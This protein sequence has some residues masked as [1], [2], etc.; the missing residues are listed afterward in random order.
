MRHPLFGTRRRKE[1][2]NWQVSQVQAYNFRKNAGK[3]KPE[4]EIFFL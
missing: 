4:V 2:L 1:L 3:R